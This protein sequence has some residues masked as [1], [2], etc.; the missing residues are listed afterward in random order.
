MKATVLILA[1]FIISHV[2]FAQD[3]SL[4]GGLINAEDSTALVGATVQLIN[5]KDTTKRHIA[6]ADLD[7]FFMVKNL[8]NAFYKLRITSVGIEPFSNFVKVGES[9][10]NIG[11]LLLKPNDT[12]LDDV[13]VTGQVIPVK[14]KGDTTEYN[15]LAYKTNPDASAQDLLEKMPGFIIDNGTVQAQG[16]DVQRVLVDGKEFFGNDPRA[17]LQNIPAEMIDKVEV[18]DQASDQAQFS[19]FDDG[20]T[21]K[22]VNIV[23]KSDM[24]NGQFG[25]VYAGYGLD[26]DRY[27]AGGTVNIFDH[28]RRISIIGQSNNINIQNFATEDLLGVV[29]GGS[30]RGRTGGG[31]GG[32]GG[33]SGRRSIGGNGGGSVSDFLVNS[34]GG[35]SQTHAMGINY[36]DKWGEKLELSGSYFFNRT[37]NDSN[38]GIYQDFTTTDRTYQEDNI[39]YSTNVN[40]R[41][42]M[43]LQYKLDDRNSIVMRPRVTIQKNDGFENTFSNTLTPKADLNVENIFGSNLFGLDISNNFLFRH[44]FEKAGRTAS[45]NVTTSYSEDSGDSGLRAF[46]ERVAEA[47]TTEEDL[48]QI[49]DLSTDGLSV[50]TNLSYTEPLGKK[51]QL[52]I[53]LKHSESV[54]DSGQETYDY[55]EGDGTYS[56]LRIDQSSVFESKT[57]SNAVG[58]SF[59]IVGEKVT[60]MS[61]LSLQS[62]SLQNEQSLPDEYGIYRSYFNA[63]PFAMFQYRPTRQKN[64]R[65]MYMTN[66]RTP[67]VSQLQG[68]VDKT[69]TAKWSAGNP[70]LDQTYEHNVIVRYSSTNVENSSIFFAMVRASITD[71]YIGRSTYFA[72]ETPI[73]V[74]GIEV[75]PN[76]QLTTRENMDGNRSIQSFMTYG[77]PLGFMKS[78]LNGNLAYR[79]TR[80]PGINDSELNLADNSSYTV[81]AT[82]S[83]NISEQV[84]FTLSYRTS[85]NTV[86]NSVES[87]Q[88]ANNNYQSQNL[89]GRLYIMFPGSIVFRTDMANQSNSSQS[90]TFNQ[91]YWIW[92]VSLA[93][94]IFKNQR[95]EIK[96]GVADVLSQNQSIRRT[97]S[98][99]YIQDMQMLVLQRYYMLT[100]TYRIRNFIKGAQ[101]RDNGDDD[102]RR[103]RFMQMREQ[104]GFGGPGGR[105][106]RPG[107]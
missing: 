104:G 74:N 52:E 87:R 8:E 50:T 37:D 36:S 27:H 53:S 89:R 90:G 45:F 23:T 39:S 69:N 67:S 92:N 68:V 88:S 4:K 26:E 7:G 60:F 25:N 76:V 82:L 72:Q 43:R 85:F 54:A 16:E 96:L 41:L 58:T 100:F 48:D 65:V 95:G 83:S 81:G 32:R 75:D 2:A 24:R 79:F 102:E 17:A 73:T 22:T 21:N 70:E 12:M 30:R 1:S 103:R 84:D 78:N 99:N 29:G 15:A 62:L 98:A 31:R 80:T 14:Q 55:S 66:T 40:H 6:V 107:N 56:D 46:S 106:D 19:G 63:I 49:A 18:Y 11:T 77:R 93:K 9:E 33:G 5:V 94:K 10:V 97:V 71:D 57:V 20:E 44:R 51:S 105:M 28:D 38:Q 61:R 34:Q 86:S 91:N 47:G 13:N 3:F 42:N 64:L 35:I 59:R 101:N